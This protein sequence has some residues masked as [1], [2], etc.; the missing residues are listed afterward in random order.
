MDFPRQLGQVNTLTVTATADGLVV[1]VGEPHVVGREGIKPDAV[2]LDVGFNL[3][4]VNGESES[5]GEVD[6][7][8]AKDIA[9]ALSPVTGVSAR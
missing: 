5:L 8:N 1:A 7:G 4:R 9:G 6:F 2:V 3:V